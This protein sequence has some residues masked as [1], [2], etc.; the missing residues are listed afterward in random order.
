MGPEH[1][2]QTSRHLDPPRRAYAR[3]EEEY[4]TPP[5]WTRLRL[6]ADLALASAVRDRVD[7]GTVPGSQGGQ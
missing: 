3:D 5:R 4:E 7:G 1:P 2:H 6:H